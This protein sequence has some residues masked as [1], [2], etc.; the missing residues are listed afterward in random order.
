MRL[1]F[2]CVVQHATYI[3]NVLHKSCMCVCVYIHIYIYIW[4]RYVTSF[5]QW[6]VLNKTW[7]SN[8]ASCT[9][10]SKMKTLNIFYLVIYWTQKVHMISFFYLFSTAFHTSV[11]ALWKCM[12]TSRKKFF[13]LT[14][15]PLVHH[16]L[17]LFVGPERLSPIA[18]L[19]GPRTRKSL[20]ARSGGY[21]GCGR[22][23]KDRSWIVATVEQAVC[24][25]ALSCWSKAPILRYPRR[26]DLIAGRRWFFRRSAYI[27]L[28]TVF[29]LGM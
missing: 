8:W 16:L 11:P 29:P 6:A 12:N 27:A 17:H 22:H 19:S 2:L 23:L 1:F 14:A 4:I 26:L 5:V 9:R 20:G 3:K 10:V 24:G 25:R 18:S 15:Q 13:W 7:S 28:V 21:R